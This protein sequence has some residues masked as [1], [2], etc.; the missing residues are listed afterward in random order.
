MPYVGCTSC[1]LIAFTAAYRGNA[2]HCERCGAQLPRPRSSA[3]TDRG[4]IVPR[5]PF[6]PTVAGTGTRQP[7]REE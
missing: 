7:G 2:E 4:W 1:G 6:A 5:A 3:S